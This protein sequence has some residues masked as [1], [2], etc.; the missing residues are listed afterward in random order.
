MQYKQIIIALSERKYTKAFDLIEADQIEEFF[1]PLH[2]LFGKPQPLVNDPVFW[3]T[4][5]SHGKGEFLFKSEFIYPILETFWKSRSTST[6]LIRLFAGNYPQKFIESLRLNRTF[7]NPDVL[8]LVTDSIH[9]PPA[10]IYCHLMQMQSMLKRKSALE[11]KLKTNEEVLEKISLASILILITLWFE[12]DPNEDRQAVD[13]KYRTVNKFLTDYFR[14][15]TKSLRR[16]ERESMMLD[17]VKICNKLQNDKSVVPSVWK[18]IDDVKDYIFFLSADVDHYCFD[19]KSDFNPPGEFISNSREKMSFIEGSNK[20]D[21]FESYHLSLAAL[22]T[23]KLLKEWDVKLGGKDDHELAFNQ[24]AVIFDVVIRLWTSYLGLDTVFSETHKLYTKVYS[25]LFAHAKSRYE[26]P[27]Q[28]HFSATNDPIVSILATIVSDGQGR[29][30]P[31]QVTTAEEFAGMTRLSFKGQV[32]ESEMIDIPELLFY[33]TSLANAELNMISRP[34]IRTDGDQYVRLLPLLSRQNVVIGAYTRLLEEVVRS[35]EQNKKASESFEKIVSATFK[36]ARFSSAHSLKVDGMTGDFDVIVTERDTVLIL[37]LKRTSFRENSTGIWKERTDRLQ[38]GSLQLYKLTRFIENNPEA[39][40]REF[41]ALQDVSVKIAGFV[42]SPWF[43][44]DHELIGRYRKVSWFEIR[45]A[46]EKME[47]QWKHSE[48]RL[49]AFIN[50]I[51]DDKIWPEIFGK[52][53]EF[54]RYTKE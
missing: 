14:L 43:E 27:F 11:A 1:N 53:F 8:Q 6:E 44:H 4:L 15:S 9:N 39:L 30:F 3:Q 10:Y 36:K 18:K 5:F 50:L 54:E 45:Y 47:E 33:D 17:F 29:G 31:V 52:S 24:L 19:L 48:N 46:L 12:K 16:L 23:P 21:A 41:P 42:V 25:M 28:A 49:A 51:E 2:F 37:E 20:L 7:L 40:A 34:L 26:A 22:I 35:G 32:E 13:L 38:K